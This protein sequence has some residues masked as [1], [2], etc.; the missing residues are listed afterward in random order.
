M[1][2]QAA[3]LLL[4]TSATP[5]CLVA[6]TGGHDQ[7]MVCLAINV[8]PALSTLFNQ[9][10][11][12]IFTLKIGTAL[13]VKDRIFVKI[14]LVLSRSDSFKSIH[15]EKSEVYIGLFQCRS[16]TTSYG[17]TALLV[18]LVVVSGA[19]LNTHLYLFTFLPLHNRSFSESKHILNFAI[20]CTV[21]FLTFAVTVMIFYIIK[22]GKSYSYHGNIMFVVAVH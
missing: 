4:R 13:W 8:S 1:T 6:P 2:L 22:I 3:A 20:F 5:P 7:S 9:S 18:A 21:S 10:T 16:A 12:V 14:W 15:F 19:I 11:S 17:C